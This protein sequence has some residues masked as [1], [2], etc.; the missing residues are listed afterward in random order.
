MKSRNKKHW[1]SL[2]KRY[3]NV[4]LNT[5]KRYMHSREMSFIN[6]FLKKLEINKALDIGVGNGRILKN[7]LKNSNIKNIYGID[8]SDEMIRICRKKFY[9]NERIKKL[10][11][12][13]FSKNEIPFNMKFDFI[14]SIRVL[15]YNK[16]WREMI[17]KISDSLVDNGVTVFTMP[18]KFSL[19]IFGRY[20]IPYY[21]TSRNEIRKICKE[22]GLKVISIGSFTRLPDVLYDAASD[23]I[24]SS[25][26]IAI[27]KFLAF[28]L[29]KSL[30]GR[31][32]FIAAEKK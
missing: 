17:G 13:N 24:L 11:V 9:G 6:Y 23:S 30:F 25:G 4:W 20:Y 8:I 18:N 10:E 16:N 1:D 5:S 31:V 12:C 28:L 15:K 21:R 2:G 14:S 7:Y 32:L 19:N 22:N 3:S 27:E 29:G 26:I